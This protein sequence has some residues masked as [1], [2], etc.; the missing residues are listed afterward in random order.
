MNRQN[1]KYRFS[2]LLLLI[3]ISAAVVPL[4]GQ[5]NIRR[6]IRIYAERLRENP[7]DVEALREIGVLC[8]HSDQF[9]RARRFLA[10]AYQLAPKDDKTVLYYGL[11]H[12]YMDSEKVALDLYFKYPDIF[13]GPY[14]QYVEG[15]YHHLSRKLIREE[16][17][18]LLK[19]EAAV[20][21]SMIMPYRIAVF[22]LFSQVADNDHQLYSMG[23]TEMLRFD[24]S[25]IPQIQVVDRVRTQ[26]LTE[27]ASLLNIDLQD[28][29]NLIQIS[30]LLGAGWY[31]SGSF[32]K[33]GEGI[34][35]VNIYLMDI[36]NELSPERFS[37]A[38]I[39]EYLIDVEKSLLLDFVKAMGITLS[40]EV[41]LKIT[42]NRPENLMT[43]HVFCQG[44][45]AEATGDFKQA[46]S[47]YEKV[48]VLDI[49]FQPSINRL[50]ESL[51]L[52]QVNADKG[53]L[54]RDISPFRTIAV[55]RPYMND[56]IVRRLRNISSN[57]G[58]YFVPSQDSRQS[59]EEAFY[60]GLDLGLDDLPDP[61]PPP[62]N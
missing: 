32:D 25:L 20:P 12:E 18:D 5:P 17:Q 43:F 22:P 29:D 34:I 38:D 16:I 50:R 14:Q 46:V 3:F 21:D 6:D 44:L 1:Q 7:E 49:R 24:L 28:Q 8:V 56:L 41:K 42:A 36:L 45:A 10:K 54:L 55:S 23:F 30:Q 19:P 62:G 13:P 37:S 26:I 35:S 31:L 11:T 33:M 48:N 15:R 61:P 51:L 4:Y 9:E 2:V 60:S 57:L 53:I 47:H 39:D 59:M 40:E 52:S 27:E 58:A